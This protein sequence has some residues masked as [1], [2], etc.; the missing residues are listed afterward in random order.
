MAPDGLSVHKGF[1]ILM[2]RGWGKYIFNRVTKSNWLALSVLKNLKRLGFIDEALYKIAYSE[3]DTEKKRLDVYYTLN[4]IRLLKPDVALVASLINQYKIKC[5]LIF[6]QHD[7][8]FPKKAAS[9]FIDL[10]DNAD[11]HEAPLGHWL[12]TPALDEYLV[13]LTR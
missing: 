8:L 6:G 10:L 2:H 1:H 13:N 9:S 12:V 11:V 4:L 3:M 5:L 7:N